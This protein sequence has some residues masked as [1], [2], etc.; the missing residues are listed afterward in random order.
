ML[1]G[2]ATGSSIA[3]NK[4]PILTLCLK[5]KKYGR[6]NCKGK[7][8]KSYFFAVGFVSCKKRSVKKKNTTCDQH[9]L[10]IFSLW[11]EI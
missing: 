11:S 10:I 2:R 9:F 3:D 8:A 6:K 1:R 5:G 7:F 4:T